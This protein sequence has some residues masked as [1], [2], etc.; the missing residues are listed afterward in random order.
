LPSVFSSDG[1]WAAYSIGYSETQQEKLRKD[2]KP[3]QNKLGLTNLCGEQL[4]EAEELENF[5]A[6]YYRGSGSKNR[7]LGIDGCA[8]DDL[9]APY[10]PCSLNM[11]EPRNRLH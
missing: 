7:S 9:D 5:E 3:V 10:A 8:E 6:C 2:K 1:K 11:A 4:S